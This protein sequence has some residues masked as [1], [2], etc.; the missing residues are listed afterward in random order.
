MKEKFYGFAF[1]YLSFTSTSGISA[2]RACGS[3]LNFA[4]VCL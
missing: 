2:L 1:R 4:A 3:S